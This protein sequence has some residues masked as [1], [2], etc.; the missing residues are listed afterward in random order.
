MYTSYIFYVKLFNVFSTYFMKEL[1][2]HEQNVYEI[3][4]MYYL[5]Q[6]CH[7]LKQKKSFFQG[8]LKVIAKILNWYSIY[9]NAIAT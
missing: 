2:K 3:L 6:I 8:H 5:P 7:I 9:V 1:P 4:E